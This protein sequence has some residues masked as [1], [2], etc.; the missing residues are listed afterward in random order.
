MDS[1]NI[2]LIQLGNYVKPEIKESYGRKWILNGRNNG[3]F[4]YVIDRKNGSPTNESV[5]N[6]YRS[7]LFGRGIRVK[8][9]EDLYDELNE[10]FSKND[11]RNTLDDFKTFGMFSLKL[12]RSVGGGIARVKHFPIDKLG[13]GK[14]NDKGVIDHVFYCYDWN[15]TVKYKPE[16]MP[17]FMGR[18]T[19][20]EM[21]LVYKPYQSGNFYYSYPDYMAGLQYA[22]IEEEISNFSI[23]H[24]RNGLSFGYVINFNNGS[25]VSE[26]MRKEI[27][28][29][30]TD[31]LTGSRNAGQF[32]L[33]FNEGKEA[34]VTVVPLDV[35]DAHNQWESLREDAKYQI[36]TA[37]GVTSP[38]LFGLPSA[39]GFGSNADELNVASKLL[40]DY[41]ISPKQ[42]AFID[43]I[44]PVLEIAGLETD[45]EFIELRESYTTEETDTEV[46]RDET[47]EDLEETVEMTSHQDVEYNI[48]A[49][50]AEGEEIDYSQWQLVDDRRCDEMTL[51]ETQLNTIFQFARVP[52][53]DKNIERSRSM[54]D[55]SLFKIRYKYAGNPLPEREFCRKVMFSGKVFKA[56]I[57]NREQYITPKMGKG[58]SNTYN[59]FLFKGGVNC[60]HWWQRVIYLKKDNEF[61][62]VNK[63]RKMILE[64]E[65]EER[66]N[67]R[68]EQNDPRVA[69]IASPSNNYWK[70]D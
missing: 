70:A 60:K 41:Q 3:F 68:W 15:N 66:E 37:H 44:K 54:Q 18:M 53:D 16:E 40:Q 23:N 69:Q 45:L 5:L 12:V 20:K 1:N 36:L 6:V 4:Q 51:D 25:A 7:L 62:S 31:K 55:T 43:A 48:E 11:Q 34:E 26:E 39:S 29:R 50:L 67:A 56:E 28:R 47:V 63:A 27:E 38:L 42:E 32:I 57:L 61:I 14:A 46:V 22:Q 33:S 8:G 24:I 52:R 21:I 64:L 58:G 13:M 19:E 2:Q 10:I 30:I 59:P 9:Q 49:F 17:V 65:P 35:N